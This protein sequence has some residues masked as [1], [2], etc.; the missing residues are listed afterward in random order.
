[1]MSI[2]LFYFL[3]SLN[4]EAKIKPVMKPGTK[5]TLGKLISNKDCMIEKDGKKQFGSLDFNNGKPPSCTP[6]RSGIK[7]WW[8][9]Y[10]SQSCSLHMIENNKPTEVSLK[11]N[12][13]AL[14]ITREVRIGQTEIIP[15]EKTKE[16]PFQS[17]EC[18][19]ESMTSANISQS[20]VEYNF[21][22]YLRFTKES[23]P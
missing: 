19:P 5:V 1:M 6:S 12:P 18:H 17:I 9:D 7:A 15:F 11:T 8:R 2:H 10:H 20:S 23:K 4:S 21:G 16:C 3:V 14:C 13:S 22:E